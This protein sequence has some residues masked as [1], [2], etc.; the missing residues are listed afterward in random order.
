[1]REENGA[2]YDLLRGY[3]R[4]DPAVRWPEQRLA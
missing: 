2:L 4:H 3:Y 1:L